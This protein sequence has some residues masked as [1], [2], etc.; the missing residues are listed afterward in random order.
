M[1]AL[2]I[3]YNAGKAQY[4]TEQNRILTILTVFSIFLM[5]Y[6]DAYTFIAQNG[7]FA[8]PQTGNLI[9]LVARISS[10]EWQQALIHVFV[11]LG[12]I[13]GAFIGQ[14]MIDRITDSDWKKYRV[15][16]FLPLVLLLIV[17][18]IQQFVSPFLIG[19]LLGL[20]SGYELIIFRKIKG[21]T[22]NNAVMTGNA[23]NLMSNLYEAIFNEDLRA[24]REFFILLSG[25]V[26]FMLG[27]GTGTL[28]LKLFGPF[29]NLW[30]AFSITGV[31]YIWLLIKR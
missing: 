28:V 4:E 5:G 17:S 29:Y 21:I 20:L 14:A 18:L 26:I 8:S 1:E 25:I 27:V 23:K 11:L 6:I 7:V 15:Y 16:L 24:R 19:F 9:A 10:G 31:F 30:G 22:I 3:R 2:E 12:F 13:I